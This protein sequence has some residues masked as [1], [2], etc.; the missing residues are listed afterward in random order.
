MLV[1]FSQIDANLDLFKSNIK[2]IVKVK[3]FLL[4]LCSYFARSKP[5]IDICE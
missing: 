1:F 4:E 2:L 5:V 3:Q